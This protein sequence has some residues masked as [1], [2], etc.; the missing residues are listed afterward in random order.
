MVKRTSYPQWFNT[1]WSAMMELKTKITGQPNK[2]L[3]YEQCKKHKITEKDAPYII[4]CFKN[5]TD[6]IRQLRAQGQWAQE[7][8]DFERWLKNKTWE[9]WETPVE[10]KVSSIVDKHTDR[11]WSAPSHQ[12]YE[13]QEIEVAGEE[14]R[15]HFRNERKKITNI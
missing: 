4:S 13:H 8:Q 15:E 3:A 9:N 1:M 12:P 7:H 2:H 10:T 5:H 6:H 11:S 14:V